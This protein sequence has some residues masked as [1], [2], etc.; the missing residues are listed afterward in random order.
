MTSFK[1]L[2]EVNDA[3]YNKNALT[4]INIKSTSS[5]PGVADTGF[6]NNNGY[7]YLNNVTLN[8]IGVSGVTH[9]RFD[10]SGLLRYYSKSGSGNN[11][12]IEIPNYQNVTI[13]FTTN[14]GYTWTF[15]NGLYNGYV[16]A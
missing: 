4:V 15:K 11:S 8:G 10:A 12:F 2:P 7:W 3:A 6:N 9:I 1:P 13:T 16:K 14:N 5:S